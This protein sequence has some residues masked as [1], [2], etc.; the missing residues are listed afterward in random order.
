MGFYPEDVAIRSAGPLT[1]YPAP[2][3]PLG[4]SFIGTAF[5]EFNLIRLA[6]AFEQATRVRLARKAFLAAVPR[7]QLSDIVKK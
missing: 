4:L 6:F 3:V 5:D 1:V 7:T 2:N